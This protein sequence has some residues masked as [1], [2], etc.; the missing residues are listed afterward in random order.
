MS[1]F[2][3]IQSGADYRVYRMLLS[4]IQHIS[5]LAD[6]VLKLSGTIQSIAKV[7]AKYEHMLFLGRGQSYAIALEAALKFKE[8]T[9]LHAHATPL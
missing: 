4:G 9:Y 3:S 6:E 7:L 8:I 5:L 2:F 1:I